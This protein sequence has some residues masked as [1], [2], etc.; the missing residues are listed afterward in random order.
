MAEKSHRRQG[1]GLLR[2]LLL[3]LLRLGTAVPAED[4]VGSPLRRL[5][6]PELH[7]CKEDVRV[8]M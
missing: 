4:V 1:V 6:A 7:I 3:L 2:H 5:R 8:P